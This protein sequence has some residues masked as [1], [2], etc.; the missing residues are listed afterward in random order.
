MKIKNS[1]KL[2][3][4][5]SVVAASFTG[6]SAFAVVEPPD[7]VELL[8]GSASL[9]AP[10]L[11][12]RDQELV[13]STGNSTVA[14][15][16]VVYPINVSGTITAETNPTY[17][18]R[19]S[20]MTYTTAFSTYRVTNS[21]L[22]GLIGANSTSR[23]VYV[24][25]ADGS[26]VNINDNNGLFVCSSSN[27][28]TG[29]LTAVDPNES[30]VVV[31]LAAGY[32]LVRESASY[33]IVEGD[34][35]SYN[36]QQTLGRIPVV[37][38]ADG[39]LA[40]GVGSFTS[41]LAKGLRFS[42]NL[43]NQTATRLSG[44]SANFESLNSFSYTLTG[45]DSFTVSSSASATID[46]SEA[47][48]FSS[49]SNVNTVSYALTGG[50]LT[51]ATISNNGM[52]TFNA[53]QSG[54]YVVTVGATILFNGRTTPVNTSAD[55]TVTV[56][57]PVPVVTV[58]GNLTTIGITQ[59]TTYSNAF[60]ATNSPLSNGWLLDGLSSKQGLSITGGNLSASANAT[61]WTGT[62][63]ANNTTGASLPVT[64]S[65]IVTPVTP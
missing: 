33:T 41:T 19:G 30:G 65:I 55:L 3:A 6:N 22:L 46:A 13:Y 47:F 61:N 64:V 56:Q 27:L 31:N 57:P 5:A 26:A 1:I 2:L 54:N 37:V 44:T 23:L 14:A 60:S 11:S 48:D 17:K 8:S 7:T 29:N 24:A 28:I 50:N 45:N 25:D 38:A 52:I 12:P 15:P 32:P 34:N 4:A 39:Y 49:Y 53:T 16:Y 51:G 62:I 36:T 9:G 35:I 58:T 59:N 40:Y 21:T 20:V 63:T 43:T 18:S 10:V 42:A